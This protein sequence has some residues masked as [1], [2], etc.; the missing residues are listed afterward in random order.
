MIYGAKSGVLKTGNT[1]MEYIRF[2][3]GKRILV[4]LPGLGDSLRSMKG[5]ALPMA[6]MYRCF[7]KDF[8]VYA[9]SRKNELPVGYT[10]RDMARDQAEAMEQL[11]IGCLSGKRVSGNG[12]R[13]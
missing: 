1:T 10:T 11:G 12:V 7:A 8:T 9:F 2:G 5:T 13:L 4:M 6:L 3:S